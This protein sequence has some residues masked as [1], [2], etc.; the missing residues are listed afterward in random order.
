VNDI[1]V[2]ADIPVTDLERASKFYAHVTGMAVQA[3]PGG[4]DVA[5]ISPPAGQGSGEMVVSADLYVGGKPSH[6]GPTVYLGTGGDID[7]MAARVVEAGGKMLQEKQNMGEMV[8]WIAFFEDTE[9]NR[10][11]MQQPVK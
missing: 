9:G 8:G 7:G 1:I 3:M 10:I 2:W 4:M 6:D 11:G 5:V